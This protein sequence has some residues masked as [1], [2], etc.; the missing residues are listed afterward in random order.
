[1]TTDLFLLCHA[2]TRAMKTG[3]FPAPDDALDASAPAAIA[4]CFEDG[5]M[6]VV[7]SPARAARE[8]AARMSRVVETD[9]SFG[10]L[11]YGRWRG[12]S[13]K[14]VSAE[15]SIALAAWLRD[16][17]SRPHGGESIEALAARVMAGL[18]RYTQARR[19]VI[20]THAIVV[21]AV[22]ACVARLPLGSVYRMDIAPLACVR[23]MHDAQG[24]HAHSWPGTAGLA[25]DEDG[26][27]AAEQC[28]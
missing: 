3:C 17:A 4:P 10:D 25:P 23:F 21:K 24:W 13:L 5:P 12:R 14:E 16:P 6:R 20:V 27:G 2:A 1:M 18:E 11:D 7:A 28:K 19:C 8:T 26:A 15:D 9:P 22:F